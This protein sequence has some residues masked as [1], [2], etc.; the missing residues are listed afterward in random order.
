MMA[1]W[2]WEVCK[3]INNRT[4]KY[5]ISKRK[6]WCKPMSK[7]E[8]ERRVY[9]TVKEYDEL[10]AKRKK[11]EEDLKKCQE[12]SKKKEDDAKKAQ[13]KAEKEKDALSK[14]LDAAEKAAKDAEKRAKDAEADKAKAEKV[15]KDAADANATLEGKVKDLEKKLASAPKAATPDTSAAAAGIDYAMLSDARK[16][17][18]S[19]ASKA[20]NDAIAAAHAEITTANMF[21]HSWHK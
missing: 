18:I 5:Y 8:T 17:D 9:Y 11:L 16:K 2:F 12:D 13:E 10:E 21:M 4:L 19:D 6:V 14:K 7:R 1:Y 20:L 15:L 3:P